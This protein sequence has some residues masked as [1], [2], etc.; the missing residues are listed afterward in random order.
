MMLWGL[1]LLALGVLAAVNGF[2]AF[3]CES[4]SLSRTVITCHG[5][6][7]GAAG[8]SIAG[9]GLV[10]LGVILGAAGLTGLRRADR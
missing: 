6:G 4:V 7:A 5:S 9:I 2:R 1:V 3:G 8:G 10:L